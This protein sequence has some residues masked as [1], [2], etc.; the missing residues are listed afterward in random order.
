MTDS[1]Q[2]AFRAQITTLA[3]A[4]IESEEG[5]DRSMEFLRLATRIPCDRP[6]QGNHCQCRWIVMK[7]AQ[8]ACPQCQRINEMRKAKNRCR[9]SRQK[10]FKRLAA[11]VTVYRR[12]LSEPETQTDPT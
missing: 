8:G 7:A 10:N 5:F 2:D 11:V 6:I 4:L 9:A 12:N 1:Q 3:L